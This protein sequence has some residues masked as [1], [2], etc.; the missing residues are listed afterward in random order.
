VLTSIDR[1]WFIASVR[2]L[3]ALLRATEEIF[4]AWQAPECCFGM[5]VDTPDKTDRAGFSASIGSDLPLRLLATLS[6]RLTSNT[7]TPLSAN[8]LH[9]PAP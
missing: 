2:A 3:T 5:A 6:S 4:I 1:T 9:K 7:D 8:K